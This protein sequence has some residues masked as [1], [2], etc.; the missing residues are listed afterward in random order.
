MKRITV[1][2]WD[3]SLTRAGPAQVVPSRAAPRA[4]PAIRK[5]TS[6]DIPAVRSL[7][8]DYDVKLKKAYEKYL[9][10]HT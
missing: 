4:A 7:V 3:N 10:K 5:A 8:H 1:T 2:A 9:T 6:T